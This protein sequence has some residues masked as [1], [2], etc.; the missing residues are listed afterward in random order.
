MVAKAGEILGK[1]AKAGVQS[2]PGIR[3]MLSCAYREPVLIEHDGSLL[4][5]QIGQ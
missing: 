4:D 2:L 1:A 3:N 5:S